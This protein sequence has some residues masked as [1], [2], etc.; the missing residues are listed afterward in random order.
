MANRIFVDTQFLLYLRT[1]IKLMTMGEWGGGW[2]GGVGGVMLCQSCQS[3]F[4][5]YG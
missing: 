4:W 1:D 5:L 3:L 2:G